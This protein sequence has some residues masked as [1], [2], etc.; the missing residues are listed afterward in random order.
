[1]NSSQSTEHRFTWILTGTYLAVLAWIILWKMGVEFS[2]RE[3]RS[4]NLIPFPEVLVSGG[5]LDWSQVILNVLIFIPFGMYLQLLFPKNHWFK[6]LFYSFLLSI[7]L[8]TFQYLFRI[9]AFDTTDLITNTAGGFMGLGM[10]K[11]LQSWTQ[12]SPRVQKTINVLMA[13]GTLGILTL[14]FLLKLDMLPI[15]YR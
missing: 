6:N 11:G 5:R 13:L 8:E 2:Y 7:F 3:T 9:G 1:M 14:L 4:F 15:R 10:V 12:H